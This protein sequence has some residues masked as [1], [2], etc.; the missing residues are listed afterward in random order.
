M[1]LLR[2][3]SIKAPALTLLLALLFSCW[4]VPVRAAEV[5]IKA[6]IE[7]NRFTVNEEAI[8]TLT[9]HGQRSAD[10]ELPEI[11][12]LAITP[13]GHSTQIQWINGSL[14]SAV[15]LTYR[16]QAERTGSFTIAP[17]RI[18][19]DG[20]AQTARPVR[21]VV[22]SAPGSS[23]G[24]GSGGT[25]VRP[26]PA[27]PRAGKGP[28][29]GQLSVKPDKNKMYSGELLPITIRG[30]FRQDRRVTV[31]GQPTLA[32]NGFIMESL[33][34][35]PVQEEIIRDGIPCVQLTWYGTVSAIRPGKTDLR[36]TLPITVLVPEQ[37]QIP[38]GMF[39]DPFFDLDSF[40]TTTAKRKSPC[41]ASPFPSR[42]WPCR[43]RAGPMIFPVPSA[44]FLCGW[45]PV[46]QS[47]LQA[48]RSA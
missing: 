37:R 24:S 5:R 40:F 12:G 3:I 46:P 33:D 27:S 36:M 2:T 31:N 43:I 29:D 48:I 39:N 8:L 19:V 28:G 17:I 35:E 47:F 1:S 42:S 6:H 7:P 15:T 13:L 26:P 38:R 14:S 23:S 25:P 21:I 4:Q 34:E 18:R 30:Y 22:V 45:R 20:K 32:G 11:D 41:K 16:V 10:P 9:I 44:P